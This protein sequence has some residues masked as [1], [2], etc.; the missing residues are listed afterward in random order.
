[1]ASS[2]QEL[3][4]LLVP[5]Q[6]ALEDL[7]RAFVRTSCFHPEPAAAAGPAG[8]ATETVCSAASRDAEQT[9]QTKTRQ[10]KGPVLEEP[11]HEN[12]SAQI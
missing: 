4:L 5:L 1:M 10:E 12:G 9:L 11:T 8:Y 3:L 7:Q 6:Q 2:L